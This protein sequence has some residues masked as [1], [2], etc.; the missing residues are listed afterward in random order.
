MLVPI[1]VDAG[2]HASSV[3]RRASCSSQPN[4]DDGVSERNVRQDAEQ[5]T[6]EARSPQNLPF[7]TWFVDNPRPSSKS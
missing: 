5:G 3:Q 7:W 6:L 4:R 2:A 1:F